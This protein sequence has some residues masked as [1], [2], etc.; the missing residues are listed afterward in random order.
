M[1]CSHRTPLPRPW[2]AP[3]PEKGEVLGTTLPSSFLLIGMNTSIRNHGPGT[4]QGFRGFTSVSQWGGL[5][6]REAGMG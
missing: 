5:G 1:D 4:G 3:P 2:E 6:S